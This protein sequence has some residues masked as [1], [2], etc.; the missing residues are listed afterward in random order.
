MTEENPLRFWTP[1]A[2]ALSIN[3][4]WPDNLAGLSGFVDNLFDKGIL[5]SHHGR[6]TGSDVKSVLSECDHSGSRH[7]SRLPAQAGITLSAFALMGLETTLEDTPE[8]KPERRHWPEIF[9]QEYQGL[10]GAVTK[11]AKDHRISRSLLSKTLNAAGINTGKGGRPRKSQ[12]AED[13]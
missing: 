3:H 4:T 2:L 6:V 13:S 12:R 8:E 9:R 11:M 1:E 10:P 7:H 5:R